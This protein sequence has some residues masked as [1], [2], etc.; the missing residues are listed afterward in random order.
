VKLP[1]AR[2]TIPEHDFD[3]ILSDFTKVLKSGRMTLGPY[4]EAFESEYASFMGSGYAVAVNSGTSALEIILRCLDATGKKVIIPTNTF[5]AT[6]AAALH[7]GARVTLVDVGNHMMMDPTQLEESLD[8]NTAAV[9]VVHIGGYVH[10]EICRIRDICSDHHV[11]LIED[12]AHAQ[13]SRLRGKLAG[14]FG[15]AAA[16]SFYP[17]KVITA[18]EGGMIT[19]NDLSVVKR[20]KILRDQGKASFNTNYH[21]ELGYN[22]R[23]CE[24]NAIVGLHQLRH[25]EEF[26]THRRAIAERYA[27]GLRVVD[28]LTPL[29]YPSESTPNFYKYIAILGD[30]VSRARVKSEL[31]TKY[32]V[33]LSGE[34]YEVP[35]HLQPV[36]KSAQVDRHGEMREAERVCDRHVCLPV[37][38]DMTASEQEYALSAL[39]SV[40]T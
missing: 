36:F 22:W 26:V 17:T 6:P 11:P 40:F 16:F 35:C 20:A 10:P 7:T 2:V 12:A 28:G 19:T 21:V 13:G 9:V 39:G 8:S 29:A 34:V 18:G 14:G 33:S 38:S 3:E 5:F 4:T 24:L 32:D 30:G 27:E 37:Y 23:M 25:L 15:E 31:K 1:P